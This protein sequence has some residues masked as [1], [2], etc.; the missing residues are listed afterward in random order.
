MAQLEKLSVGWHGLLPSLTKFVEQWRPPSL[1]GET[2]Y[3]DHLLS[4][5]REAVPDDTKVEK[6]YRHR[7]TTIDVW[8][9]WQGVFSSEEVAFELKVNL[10]RKT[11]YDRLV[12]QLEGM[13]PAKYKTIVVLIGETDP[14]L[15]GRLKER[16][17]KHLQD[18]ITQ[19]MSIVCVPA[20]A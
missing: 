20:G 6:E 17:A 15:L 1:R 4:A 16:Y 13:E 19:T 3:R 14:S 9:K 5:L 12:G 8:L 11:D 7:G 10:L 2:K 18:D